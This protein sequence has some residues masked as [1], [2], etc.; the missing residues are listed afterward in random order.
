MA[1][2]PIP[3][4]APDQA[5][6]GNAAAIQIRNAL[7]GANS[8]KPMPAFDAFT[9]ALD[10]RA[11]GAIEATDEDLNIYQYAGDAAKLYRLVSMSWTDASISGGYSTGTEEVWEFARWKNQILA[12]NWNDNIQYLELGGTTF[13]D[14]TTAFKC[15]VLFV[16]RDHVV[17]ANTFDATDGNVPD[18][19]RTCSID[20][21]TSW[22]VD[23]NTGAIARDLKSGPII[24]GYGGDYGLLFTEENTYRMDWVGAPT[25]FE[26]NPTLQGL[27]IIAP[28]ASARIGEDVF[29]WSNQG[30][31]VIRNGTGFEPIGAG[32]VDQYLFNDLDDVN[33][34]R[35][36]TVADPRSGKIFWLYPG[37]DGGGQPNRLVCFDKNF[38]KWSIIDVDADMLWQ[39]SGIGTTLDDLDSI[40]TDLDSL[41]TS[42]DSSRWKGGGWPL[43]AAFDTDF[44]H[45][46]FSGA[47][48]T[49]I[50]ETKEVEINEG[51]Q[52]AIH[53]YRPLIDGGSFTACVGYRNDQAEERSYTVARS[54][55]ATGRVTE[56]K[57]ARYHTFK[58]QVFDDWND[59][60]GVQM[61][62][63]DARVS[64]R[65][66]RS[67]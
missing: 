16:L 12:T 7:P 25:W 38:N 9:D 20:D 17:A 52:T 40:T 24:K 48:M 31:V 57:N 8:Y 1:V 41:S 36:S 37:Q 29:A 26:I 28:R 62:S 13:A 30:M 23:P 21:E 46:F 59:A 64:G 65:R 44:K 4:W 43:L 53:A 3:D 11:R 54:P 2:I 50:L 58:M 15:R 47:P 45:G 19:V 39:A 61:D 35:M 33:R 27:G 32:R 5:D 42:L 66:G 10:A 6:L 34:F 55:T 22:T 51:R 18:R 60:I 49:A 67:D 56:R 63:K 14:L